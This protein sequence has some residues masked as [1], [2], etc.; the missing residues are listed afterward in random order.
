MPS[1][2]K[3]VGFSRGVPVVSTRRGHALSLWLGK[4]SGHAGDGQR[5]IEP[6][7][8]WGSPFQVRTNA[9]P[10]E[11]VCVS[12]PAY[13]QKIGRKSKSECVTLSSSNIF[14]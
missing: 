13:G 1:D 3:F 6:L 12:G 4:H 5:E 11:G 14:H 8:S 9:N 10:W 2:A 7:E